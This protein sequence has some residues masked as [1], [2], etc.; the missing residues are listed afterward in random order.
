LG[1]EVL[2]LQADVAD[3]PQMKRALK[4]ATSRFGA[5][6]GFIHAAGISSGD[7]FGAIQEIRQEQC[8]WHFQPKVYGLYVLAELLADHANLEFCLL[9]SSLSSILG[10]LGFVGYSAAN[11]FMDTFAQKHSQTA[12]TRW[13]SVAWDTWRTR[14]DQHA[15]IGRTVAKFEM[16][17]AEGV[18]AFECIL[19]ND[20]G[21]HVINSTGD[22]DARIRQWL[23]L[24]SL[25]GGATAGAGRSRPDLATA[26]VAAS[27]DYEQTVTQVWQ[28]LLG[29]EGIGVHD[30]FFDLG[31]NSLILVQM[32]NR[33]QK[34][35]GRSIPIAQLFQHSNI[36][37]LAGF[38]SGSLQEEEE[39]M[40]IEERGQQSRAALMQQR[41]RLRRE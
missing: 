9:F 32:H 12:P 27:N 1:A 13:I 14:E 4:A 41:Q 39:L 30:N 29:I 23:T 7:A 3:A 8:E 28:G 26:Y 24:E 35:F 33:I 10:G 21:A 17:P 19:A 22:L 34:S 20:V 31:G 2:V 18:A 36:R 16:T 6:H 25:R 37:D 15:V 5:I 11:A 40:P 38:L